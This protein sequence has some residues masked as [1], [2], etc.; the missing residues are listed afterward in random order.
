MG[1]PN[2]DK[3]GSGHARPRVQG[4]GYSHSLTLRVFE[5]GMKGKEPSRGGLEREDFSQRLGPRTG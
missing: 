3:G 1:D 5:L 4:L 2:A